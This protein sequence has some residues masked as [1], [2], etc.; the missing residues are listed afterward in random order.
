MLTDNI[1]TNSYLKTLGELICSLTSLEELHI[2][3]LSINLLSN[4]QILGKGLS[5]ITSLKELHILGCKMPAKLPNLRSLDITDCKELE[6]WGL[7]R[8]ELPTCSETTNGCG[9]EKESSKERR[10]PD[11]LISLCINV[12]PRKQRG[13]HEM[14]SLIDFEITGTNNEGQ[15]FAETGDPHPISSLPDLE[16]LVKGFQHL[17]SLKRLEIKCSMS[18]QAEGLP[19]S[20]SFHIQNFSSL[21]SQEG[22]RERLAQVLKIDLE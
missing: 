13:S 21:A 15:S 14:E 8:M 9:G 2:T 5:G 3:S 22:Q 6:E 4:L 1:S 12:R 18:I 11:T 10:L 7:S 16:K 19:T 20:P 17:T